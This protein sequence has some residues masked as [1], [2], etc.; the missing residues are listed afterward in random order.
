MKPS[1]CV[2]IF[3]CAAPALAIGALVG[4]GMHPAAGV[5]AFA[6]AFAHGWQVTAP[7]PERGE[8]E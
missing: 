5:V 1:T 6:I 4:M 7:R 8:R 2:R 3:Y